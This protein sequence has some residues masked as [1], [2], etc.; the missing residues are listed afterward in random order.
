MS[1]FGLQKDVSFS[2]NYQFKIEIYDCC[3]FLP[4]RVLPQI[5]QNNLAHVIPENII[6]ENI[7]APLDSTIELSD[8]ESDSDNNNE[9]FLTAHDST[10]HISS[11]SDSSIVHDSVVNTSSSHSSSDSLPLSSSTPQAGKCDNPRTRSGRPYSST[12]YPPLSPS[13]T[14]STSGLSGAIARARRIAEDLMDSHPMAAQGK[15]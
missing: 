10:L 14:P 11:D 12:L 15:K 13:A 6:G 9:I 3:F 7:E 4:R 2:K 5:L 1:Q 8:S